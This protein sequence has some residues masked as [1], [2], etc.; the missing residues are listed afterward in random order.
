MTVKETK[1]I[2][3]KI[4]DLYPNSKIGDNERAIDTLA[5]V[6]QECFAD[7]EFKFVEKALRFYYNTDKSGFPPQTSHIVSIL[8]NVLCKPLEESDIRYLLKRA[9]SNSTYN[10]KKEFERLPDDLKKL[11][12]HPSELKLRA[13]RT[14]TDNEFWYGRI[15]KDYRCRVE[16]GTLNNTLLLGG[17]RQL[18]IGGGADG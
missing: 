11:V 18:A 12:G 13:S 14:D 7:V 17:G 16:N 1:L 3:G 9:I 5:D 10:S 2:L 15:I 6:W 8:R 4:K